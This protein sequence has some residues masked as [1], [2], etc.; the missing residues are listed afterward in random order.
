MRAIHTRRLHLCFSV[1]A[2]SFSGKT[3]PVPTSPC[4]SF[5]PAPGLSLR[6]GL[7]FR[8]TTLVAILVAASAA[9]LFTII[10]PFFLAIKSE[11]IADLLQ[12]RSQRFH[13]LREPSRRLSPV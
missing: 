13:C 1:S 3:S 4:Y 5:C 6:K 7:S 11:M 10:V 2:C 9:A 12:P 8:H